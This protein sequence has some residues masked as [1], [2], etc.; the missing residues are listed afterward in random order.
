MAIPYDNADEIPLLQ[1]FE[2][3]GLERRENGVVVVATYWDLFKNAIGRVRTSLAEMA[4]QHFEPT[5]KIWKA[6]PSWNK[7]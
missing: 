1:K 5:Q 2:P 4:S 7:T 3:N 6:I